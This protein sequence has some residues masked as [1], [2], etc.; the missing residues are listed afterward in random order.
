[1]RPRNPA[2]NGPKSRPRFGTG[3]AAGA[4]VGATSPRAMSAPTSRMGSSQTPGNTLG[5]T[6]ATKALA[7]APPI[8]RIR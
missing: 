7:S 8:D 6:S 5:A 2:K 4:A 3:L 1:M